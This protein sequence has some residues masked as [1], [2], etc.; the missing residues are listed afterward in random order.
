MKILVVS[1]LVND[2]FHLV[3]KMLRKN[4]VEFA[5]KSN[6]KKKLLEDDY[7][8]IIAGDEEYR[9]DL[10]DKCKNLK[11]I[12]RCGHG[13]DNIDY[14]YSI[15]K[16]I[17]VLNTTGCL[18]TTVAEITLG[19]MIAALRNFKQMNKAVRDGKWKRVTGRKLSDVTVGI[20]GLGGIGNALTWKLSHHKANT[21]FYDIEPSKQRDY[22]YAKFKPFEELLSTSDIVTLHCD[23]N[24]TSYH[25]IDE[26]ALHLMK[27]GGILINM[28]R[29]NVVDINA[30]KDWLFYNSDNIAILDVFP[31]E[32]NVDR[33]LL[34]MDNVI[35]SPH[36]AGS[37]YNSIERMVKLCVTQFL[38]NEKIVIREEQ[39]W[40]KH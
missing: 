34:S 22:E 10:I 32:P 27:K 39:T 38:L 33:E 9:K 16:G 13:I 14:E 23:L 31:N 25:L 12:S 37:T 20:I 21:I 15:N 30:L 36:S 5:K 17:P 26:K 8:I 1:E 4:D 24:K 19:Y 28:A 3:E 6:Y 7:D 35:L 11:L 18:D 40:V 2:N 29:G